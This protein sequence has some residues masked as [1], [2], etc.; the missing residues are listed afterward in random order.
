MTRNTQTNLG[1]LI[2]VVYEEFVQMY[3][4]A[5]L[6]SV[7]AAAVINDLIGED[8]ADDTGLEDAA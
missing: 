4:D 2:A 3:G 6:A 5:E 1:D 8:G 7:A